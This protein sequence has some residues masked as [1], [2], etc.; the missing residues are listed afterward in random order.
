MSIMAFVQKKKEEA[1]EKRITTGYLS[2]ASSSLDEAEIESKTIV[3]PEQLPTSHAT[4]SIEK[5]VEN[6]TM[7]TSNKTVIDPILSLSSS[8]SQTTTSSE[9]F[10]P[11]S[12]ATSSNKTVKTLTKVE[13][14]ESNTSINDTTN[15]PTNANKKSIETESKRSDEEI[16][17]LSKTDQ[18]QKPTKKMMKKVTSSKENSNAKTTITED[19]FENMGYI[20]GDEGY[21][22][23]SFQPPAPIITQAASEEELEPVVL[24][25]QQNQPSETQTTNPVA[26]Q[27]PTSLATSIEISNKGDDD[28]IEK[29]IEQEAEQQQQ[30]QQSSEPQNSTTDVAE[31]LP[32]SHATSVPEYETPEVDMDK[33]DNST[34]Q[35]N[36][37]PQE[38]PEEEMMETSNDVSSAHTIQQSSDNS[39]VLV[40]QSAYK[41]ITQPPQTE[42]LNSSALTQSDL[43]PSLG[44]YTPESST[45]SVHS[46]HG[47]SFSNGLG[48]T[49]NATVNTNVMESPNATVNANV[50]ESPNSISS[51][52]LNASGTPTAMQQVTQPQSMQQQQTQHYNPPSAEMSLQQQQQQHVHQQQQQQQ[53][54][55]PQA[56]P[57]NTMTVPSPAASVASNVHPAS[58]PSQSPHSQHN[59]TSPHPQPSPHQTSPHPMTISPAAHSPYQPQPPQPQPSPQPSVTP[60]LAQNTRQPARSPHVQQHHSQQM[61]HFQQMSRLVFKK[62]YRLFIIIYIL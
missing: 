38:Q 25:Q 57:H 47:G 17:V 52:D 12:H 46:I 18:E 60:G 22:D 24:E 48:D 35:Y 3:A 6:K 43:G 51:V 53:S 13:S 44:V 23:K 11:A 59:M 9:Q 4:S 2:P 1:L 36:Q 16:E 31:Q 26:E 19:E 8:E 40:T 7:I 27:L 58:L 29:P 15:I 5:A 41:Q 14:V 37:N 56:S 32:T 50:M 55:V 49:T 28:K 34:S 20:S 45:N 10:P 42:P 54:H 30:L 21:A 33:S 39:S 62:N 61:H